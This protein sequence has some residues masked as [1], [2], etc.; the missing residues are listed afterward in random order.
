MLHYPKSWKYASVEILDDNR[1]IIAA[2][3]VKELTQAFC[4]QDMLSREVRETKY[5]DD[6]DGDDDGDYLY[7]YELIAG[8]SEVEGC[9]VTISLWTTQGC[10]SIRPTLTLRYPPLQQQ[11]QGR[12]GDMAILACTPCT[13]TA[14]GSVLEG[15]DNDKPAVDYSPMTTRARSVATGFDILFHI[16]M[17]S[18]IAHLLH[19]KSLRHEWASL[20]LFFALMGKT[21]RSIEFGRDWG[22]KT[23]EWRGHTI[24][25]CVNLLQRS[26]CENIAVE[27]LHIYTQHQ[28]N[29]VFKA[30]KVNKDLR[31][32][33]LA[34]NRRLRTWDIEKR[35]EHEE[36]GPFVV[37]QWVMALMENP[38]SNLQEVNLGGLFLSN[39]SVI[40]SLA[41]SLPDLPLKKT[42][43]PEHGSRGG[44]VDI[45]VPWS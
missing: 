17:Q 18:N 40:H 31:V 45:P 3:N 15:N 37:D 1:E 34:T 5:G 29:R 21:P 39:E 38:R 2:G 30:M 28:V 36:H 19:I 26:T 16:L 9:Y 42:F 10:G 20:G 23:T 25:L 41:E 14:T 43:C 4:G 44:C 22:E 13:T 7:R 8:W 6:D 32:L 33:N 11:Q 35:I 24:S 12:S 27:S